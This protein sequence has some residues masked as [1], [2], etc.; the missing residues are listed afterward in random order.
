MIG[1]RLFYVCCLVCPPSLLWRSLR[2]QFDHPEGAS[3]QTS[4]M[5]QAGRA[6]TV[7][8]QWT[9]PRLSRT[10]TEIRICK[11]NQHEH[12]IS[13]EV[14]DWL[15]KN[16][17]VPK[18]SSNTRDWKVLLSLC[19]TC[20]M[21]RSVKLRHR[22]MLDELLEEQEHQTSVVLVQTAPPCVTSILYYMFFG[23]LDTD[24]WIWQWLVGKEFSMAELRS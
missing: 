7:A 5:N 24:V 23:L 19:R 6:S 3:K 11:A 16:P 1:L 17:Q 22:G 12:A 2:V 9:T 15:S 21:L 10:S 20:D 4:W 14:T 18:E 13:N 8:T